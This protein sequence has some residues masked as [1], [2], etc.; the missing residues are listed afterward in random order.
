MLI[1]GF[2]R[3]GVFALFRRLKARLKKAEEAVRRLQDAILAG[4]D[5]GAVKEA[6]NGAQAEREAARAEVESAPTPNH[7]EA[8]EVYAMI[9]A[10]GDVGGAIERARPD[11]LIKLYR[12]LGIEVSY[13]HLEDGGVA[14]IALRVLNERVRGA[15]R[16]QTRRHWMRTQDASSGWLLV[17]PR[18]WTAWQAGPARRRGTAM[19]R[20]RQ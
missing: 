17:A 18:S 15:S 19:M 4:V 7:L 2:C 20:A 1:A 3:T 11:S 8:A 14:T 13:Q 16:A 9:D 12:D 10:L 5:P 6:I